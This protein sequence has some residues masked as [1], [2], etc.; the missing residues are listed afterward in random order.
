MISIVIGW[1][2]FEIISFK[3]S[4]ITLSLS[5]LKQ[6]KKPPFFFLLKILETHLN[7]FGIQF[8]Y[9]KNYS[10]NINLIQKEKNSP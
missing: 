8:S 1:Q 10:I 7:I 5:F 9:P 2:R 4:K 3:S 6:H